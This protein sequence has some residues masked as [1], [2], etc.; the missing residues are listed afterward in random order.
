MDSIWKTG[1][2]A[3]V[4]ADLANAAVWWMGV[5]VLSVPPEFP[6][7][8]GVG[9]TIFF[10]SMGAAGAVGVYAVLRRISDRPAILFRRIAGI[11]LLLSF[12]PDLLLLT[13]G[14]REAVP[15][16]TVPGVILLM[17]MHVV[18]AGVIV[19]VLVGSGS[20]E[21]GVDRT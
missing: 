1:F 3:L 18:A 6:P 17:I 11:V 7:L 4:W 10:T 15:G 19:Q 13:G 14:G 9:P 21:E 20:A 8:A 5:S 16:V 2:K 12:I